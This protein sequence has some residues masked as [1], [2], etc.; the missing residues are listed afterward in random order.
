M[1]LIGDAL[2]NFID[3]LIIGAAYFTS[4]ELGIATTF[5]VIL[6]EIPQEIGDF[7]VLLHGGFSK[8]KA[9]FYNFFTALTAFIGAIVAFFIAGYSEILSA[10]ILP[11]AAGGFIYIA[12]ADLIPELH[13]ETKF[14]TSLLQ[15]IYFLLGIG[16]MFLLLLV[17]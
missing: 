17:D 15:L 10:L 14:S 1:N 5:A 6:H 12:G 8:A 13:K 9:L 11:F 7:G 4:F 3:G 2:H 16:V